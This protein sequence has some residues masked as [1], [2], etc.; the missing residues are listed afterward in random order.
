MTLDYCPPP[1]SSPN[2]GTYYCTIGNA[3]GFCHG[4]C[5]EGYEFPGGTK[6]L[7]HRCDLMTGKWLSGPDLPD[8]VPTGSRGSKR[9]IRTSTTPTTTVTESVGCDHRK[10][11]RVPDH[12]TYSCQEGV[13]YHGLLTCRVTC[14]PGYIFPDG[15]TQLEFNCNGLLQQ[16]DT[17]N[18]NIPDCV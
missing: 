7:I 15:K 8:C 9:Q 14:D 5:D 4:Y 11:L 16:W 12:G 6:V 10:A 18:I 17:R 2:H 1:T 3:V 13:Y